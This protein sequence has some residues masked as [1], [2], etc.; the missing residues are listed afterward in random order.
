MSGTQAFQAVCRS[1]S[2]RLVTIGL[3]VALVWGAAASASVI[4]TATKIKDP[5]AGTAFGSGGAGTLDSTLGA[6]WVSYLL[7]LTAT[8]T[9]TIQAVDVYILGNLQ[10]RWS[11]SNSDS[12]YDTPTPKSTNA[13]NADSHLIVA[14]NAIIGV[15]P[16]EDNPFAGSP[17]SASNGTDFGYGVGHSLAGAWAVGG[18][19]VTTLDIAYIVVKSTEIPNLTIAVTAADPTGKKYPTIYL[20][21]PSCPDCIALVDVFGNGHLVASGDTSPSVS[22]NTDFGSVALNSV[23]QRVFDITNSGDLLLSLGSPV[24]T[25][26][27]SVVGSFPSSVAPF[28][29]RTFTLGLNTATSGSFLG[30]ISFANNGFPSPYQFSLAA[31]VVPEPASVVLTGLGA[32]GI[33]FIFRRGPR[34]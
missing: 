8:G 16:T 33:A 13:R 23:Q 4:G 11:S 24:L 29:T 3:G 30:G 5:S 2:V 14:A 21:G 26:P 9:D 22:D 18:A 32:A 25:G 7:S 12:V 27:F 34:H 10:Q 19:A 17:L 1:R 15:P 28:S 6:P 31:N 20:S